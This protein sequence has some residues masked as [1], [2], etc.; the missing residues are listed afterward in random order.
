MK[1][2]ILITLF[3]TLFIFSG[4]DTLNQYAGAINQTVGTPSS[5]EMSLGLKQALEFGTNYSAERLSA[6]DGYLG[7]LAVKIL[8]PP[9]AQ[10]VENTLRSIGLNS[11]CDNV[12][13]SL[14]RAAENA[15]IEAKPIFVNAIKQMSFQD[16]SNILLGQQDAAT[17]YF[18]RTTSIALADKFRPIINNSLNKVGATRYWGDLTSRYNKIPLVKPINTDLAGYVT[19][20]AID[21]MFIEIAQEELKIRQNLAARS[22]SLLQKVF[23]YA[24]RQK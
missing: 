6:K 24:D 13:T 7:N 2:L 10:K 21:G 22:T 3:S 20:K 1:K 4:C 14:N 9:E 23:G 18:K 11:L 19:D 12:I 17:L 5:T 8:M 15:A 16:V